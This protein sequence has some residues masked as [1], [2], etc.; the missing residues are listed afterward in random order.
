[1]NNYMHHYDSWQLAVEG[2]RKLHVVWYNLISLK[3]TMYC[4]EILLLEGEE[5]DVAT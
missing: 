2:K 1:M 4:F 3:K 5:R